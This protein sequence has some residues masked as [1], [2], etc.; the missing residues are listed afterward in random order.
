MRIAEQNF[1]EAMRKYEAAQ[2][3][4]QDPA[5]SSST[6]VIR[7]GSV[8]D[9]IK[10][11]EQQ[12]TKQVI[13]SEDEQ[14][15]RQQELDDASAAVQEAREARQRILDELAAQDAK[16][17]EEALRVLEAEQ[18]ERAQRAQ[19][20]VMERERKQALERE[21][22]R[23]LEEQARLDAAE[24]RKKLELEELERLAALV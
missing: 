20:A 22:R 21:A 24:Q 13:I 14:A 17:V 6:G 7:R 12:G 15:R 10:N 5:A 9:A 18:A 19:Q 16:V 3:K 1:N 11:F 8:L 4:L 23:A 2:T